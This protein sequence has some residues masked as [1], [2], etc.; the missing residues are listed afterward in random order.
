MKNLKNAL[1]LL[2]MIATSLFCLMQVRAQQPQ[3]PQVM[4][5]RKEMAEQR[6]KEFSDKLGLNP[7]QQA[8]I[9]TIVKQNRMEMKEIRESKKDAPKEERRAAMAEQLKKG[10]VQI[11]AVLDPHQQELYKQYKEEMKTERKNKLV[12]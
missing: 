8:K 2:M 12:S 4:Q 11:N 7:D 6:F 10:N 3:D 1:K 9:K 5:G